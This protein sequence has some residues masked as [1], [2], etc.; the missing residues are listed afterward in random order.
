[1]ALP[2][3]TNLLQLT[4]LRKRID[5][6]TRNSH[7]K[8]SYRQHWNFA[9]IMLSINSTKTLASKR[10]LTKKE[11]EKTTDNME[12]LRERIRIFKED[13]YP[14]T[15]EEILLHELADDLDQ[16]AK[17]LEEI[18]HAQWLVVLNRIR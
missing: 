10:K 4:S 16:A 18:V 8:M 17:E 6:I 12:R 11:R 1:M 13:H 5:N 3:K 14:G 7:T 2:K 9:G 15:P